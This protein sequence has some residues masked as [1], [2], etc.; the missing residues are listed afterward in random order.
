MPK[1]KTTEELKQLPYAERQLLTFVII[2]GG[3]VGVELLGELTAFVDGIAPLYDRVDRTEV[4]F[5]LLQADDPLIEISD[6]P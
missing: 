5:I 2:G 4:R 3:L 1:P 6:V